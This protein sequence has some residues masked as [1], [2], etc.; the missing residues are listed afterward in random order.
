M[1]RD[2]RMV[3]RRS[4]DTLLQDAV[5]AVALVVIFFGA[6]HVPSLI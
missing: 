6:L 5:G 3:A 2:I 4:H 1:I